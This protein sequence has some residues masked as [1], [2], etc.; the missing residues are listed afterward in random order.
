MAN[1]KSLA[2]LEYDNEIGDK[3]T[4]DI[5]RLISDNLGLVKSIVKKFKPNNQQQFDEM[6]QCGRIGLWKAIQHHDPKKGKLTTIAYR[7]ILWEL[8]AYIRERK[9]IDSIMEKGTEDRKTAK[10]ID[11]NYTEI[12]EFYSDLTEQ[13]KTILDDMIAGNNRKKIAAKHGVKLYTMTKMIK[14]ILQKLKYE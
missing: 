13:E 2:N 12:S 8:F 5:N 10:I 1:R 3:T 9:R 14:T 7:P 4:E 11:F 6:V